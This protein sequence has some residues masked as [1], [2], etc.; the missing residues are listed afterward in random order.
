MSEQA[1]TLALVGSTVIDA[2]AVMISP[3]LL[4]VSVSFAVPALVKITR[5]VL[6]ALA[7][8]LAPKLTDVG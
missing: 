5:E 2:D 1:S 3:L 7:G 4:G 8:S 6:L